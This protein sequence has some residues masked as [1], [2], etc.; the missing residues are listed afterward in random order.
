LEDSRRDPLT[1]I[2]NRR[3]LADDRAMY[4][5]LQRELGED[6]AVA[7]CDVD[8]FKAYNDHFGHLAGDQALRTI[9][10]TARATLRPVDTAY[11][12]G[13]EELVLVLR[14]ADRDEA[15]AVAERVRAAVEHA[16]LPHPAGERG[17]LTISAGVAAGGA[18]LEELLACADTALYE[19]KRAGRNRVVISHEEAHS[20]A[21]RLERD[22]ADA[23]IPRHLRSLLAI[24]RAAA[25]GRG[26][27]PVLETLA[28]AIKTELAFQ[29]VVINMVDPEREE[30]RV[31]VAIG[32]V[33]ARQTL[34]HT[35][36]PMAEWTQALAAGEE[37]HGAVWLAA[38]SYDWQSESPMWTPPGVPSLSAGA[39]H[40]DDMLLLPLRDSRNKLLGVVS[41]DQPLLGQR[42][43]DAEV[44]VLMAAADHAALAL[45]YLE[46]GAVATADPGDELKLAAVMLLAETLDLR[47]PGT[48]EH[49]RTVGRL[50]RDTAIALGL[51]EHR[52]ERIHA[53]GVLHDLGKLGI[54]DAILQKAGPLDPDEWREIKRHPEVGARILE[55]A[56]MVDIAAWVRAHHERIDGRGYPNGVRGD[57][58]PLEARIL[59]VADSYE[60]MVADRPYRA[61]MPAAEA[62]AELRECAGRQFDADV[63]EAFLRAL[64]PVGV[65]DVQEL[66]VSAARG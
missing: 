35:S 26:P 33:D 12:F 40:P 52:V 8:H 7:I 3:A 53:A 56:G 41:V 21:P 48:A 14:G 30:L 59:A 9:A 17:V 66:P 5:S 64:G 16:G 6:I 23:P 13:G 37:R 27:V 60:A 20:P 44:A 18:S 25:A 19:A 43:T 63:V 49:A 31:V 46:H 24:S 22:D 32:N 45:E 36:T 2:G 54:P 4:E 62:C 42:P 61:G 55:H 1:G 11:R 10:A 29:V 34:L 50:A 58:I 38:G 65:D 15:A 39:W 51:A 57:R 47:D 28:Q